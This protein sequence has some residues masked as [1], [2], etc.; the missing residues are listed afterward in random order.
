MELNAEE[1][2]LTL[3]RELRSS[4]RHICRVN[5][6]MVNLS[7]LRAIGV[8]LVDVHGQ[9]EHL[10][11]LRVREHMELLD[12]FGDLS[13]QRAEMGRAVRKLNAV[14]TELSELREGVREAAER[15]DLLNFQI[16]EINA[17]ELQ[18]GEESSL[19]EERGRLANAEKLAALIQEA[20]SAAGEDD[21]VDGN[22]T[23][24]VSLGQLVQ[25]LERIARIDSGM[26]GRYTLAQSVLEQLRD[27][28]GDLITYS[29]RIEFN[30]RRLTEVEE[31][32]GLIQDLQRKYGADVP[33]IIR[34]GK[35][36]QA[37]LKRITG[38]DKRIRVLGESEK[39][40]LEKVSNAGIALS[41]KRCEAGKNLAKRVIGSMSELH[42]DG[43][44]F[45]VSVEWHDDPNGVLVNDS[46]RV[47]FDVNG[48]DRVEFMVAP[49]P[50]EGL[51]PIAKIASG[52]ETSRL[53]LALREV[54][55]RA[56]RKPTLIFDEID[57]GIGG[58]VGAIVGR[59]LW[60]LTA[61]HQVLCITHLPQLAGYGDAHFKVKKQLHGK[62]TYT[63][64]LVL[65][66]AD[67]LEELSEMVGA[68]GEAMRESAA[69][70]LAMAERDKEEGVAG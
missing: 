1:D 18:S 16:S 17:A 26:H 15:A 28:V 33:G 31:R 42:M 46:R 25:V 9:S 12:R 60:T 29:D 68:E 13:T 20:L 43:A 24:G 57:Q 36:A 65:E 41:A 2:D 69:Q 7:V 32:L 11:L 50:G 45:A 55:A 6:R 70:M 23:A 27:L 10:S 22:P 53:M 21:P 49:N 3:G 59:K 14:R 63:Q 37:E 40:M 47:G 35:T 54:L 5:G 61:A 44:Q 58:R 30:P 19:L 66:R 62:R 51:K 39:L 34:Y 52:G 4:G 48:I 38:T 67:R 64:V 8:R 56:D